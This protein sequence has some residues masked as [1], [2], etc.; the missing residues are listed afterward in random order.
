MWKE[1][2]RRSYS[3]TVD[4]TSIYALTPTGIE[5]LDRIIKN[6]PRGGL[7]IV[8]G[9]PGTGKTM[10]SAKFLYMGAERYGEPG[11]YV[12]F[13]EKKPI[14]YS[15]MSRIGLNFEHLESRNMFRFLDLLAIKD[16]GLP[17][18]IESI[19]ETV[20]EI[21]AKRL[22]IDSFSALAQT[23]K[24]PSDLRIVLHSLLGRI[25]WSMDCTTLLISEIPLGGARIGFG[26]E[27]F[28]ADSVIILREG[29]LD[30]RFLRDLRIVKARGVRLSEK[31]MIFTL[32]KGFNVIPPFEAPSIDVWRFYKPPEDP[33]R[34]IYSTGI[35]DLDRAVGG[36][37]KGSIALLEVDYRVRNYDY[38]S[39]ITIPLGSCFL[40]KGGGL[41]V[42]PSL[43]V[44]ASTVLEQSLLSFEDKSRVERNLRILTIRGELGYK[45]RQGIVNLRGESIEDDYSEICRIE[46]EL[47][48]EVGGPILKVIGVDRV[49]LHYG[50]NDTLKL[51]SMDVD[52][53][54]SN[55]SLTF[56]IAKPI[57][58]KLTERISP[59]AD[60]HLKLTRE[61]G[62]LILY[63]V[64]PRT[65]LYAVEV[66]VREGYTCTK[67][68]PIV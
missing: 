18:V 39:T 62:A 42:I 41:I 32:D 17:L 8:A 23:L 26:V 66:D 12:S 14:F 38:Q 34:N 55:G 40:S 52:R 25:V 63:G 68:T 35:P 1:V 20:E 51:L 44:S 37:P 21:K 61:H 5:G 29:I 45:V 58:P 11:V 19:I 9:N 49:M 60:T 24:D 56:L 48:S 15:T 4:S 3:E 67:L 27:E 64:K 36:Y 46:D 57:H 7:I 43:G 33:S 28:V 59:I 22:V 54:V 47:R 30:G 31:Q 53:V 6:L 16:S 65:G 2:D 13:A 50:L 10:F